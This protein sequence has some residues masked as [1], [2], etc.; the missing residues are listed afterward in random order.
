MKACK[1]LDYDGNY[2]NCTL[3]DGL[4]P[5]PNIKYWERGDAWVKN[6]DGSENPRNVQFC[7]LRGRV[8]EPFACHVA[9][10]SNH[11]EMYCFV[12]DK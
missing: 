5:H 1:H 9:E 10:G 2:I 4:L 7:K 3:K 11:S 8:N 6:E 12:E